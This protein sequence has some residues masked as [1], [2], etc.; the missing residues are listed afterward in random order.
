MN[1]Q[2]VLNFATH[3]ERAALC[4]QLHAL[5]RRRAFTGVNSLLEKAALFSVNALKAALLTNRHMAFLEQLS[6][7]RGLAMLAVRRPN[8]RSRRSALGL[9]ISRTC[10]RRSSR[11]FL[12]DNGDQRYRRKSR[13]PETAAKVIRQHSLIKS[14]QIFLNGRGGEIRTPDPLFPKQMRYQAALRPEPWR[15]FSRPKLI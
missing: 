3:F 15:V 9:I 13:T 12:A 8:A 11:F 10:L 1:G 6:C 5:S 14:I 7:L 4:T 2:R